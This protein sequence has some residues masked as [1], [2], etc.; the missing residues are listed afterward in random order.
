[1]SNREE[2]PTMTPET[3]SAYHAAVNAV[4][5][6][7]PI[8]ISGADL[9]RALRAFLLEAMKK[10]EHSGRPCWGALLD[11]AASL[12]N[13]PP[14]PPTLAEARKAD[15]STAEGRI[16]VVTFLAALGEAGQP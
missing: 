7:G 13:P 14:L 12:H 16:T 10:A 5:K 9:R 1:M 4:E 15:L 6:P 3:L 2:F 8:D 11:I